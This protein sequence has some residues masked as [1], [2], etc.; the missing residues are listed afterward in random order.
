MMNLR[1]AVLVSIITAALLFYI[2]DTSA[3]DGDSVGVGDLECTTLIRLYDNGDPAA[4][5]VVLQKVE[6]WALGYMSGLNK[7]ASD[8]A[9]RELSYFAMADLGYNV[10][11]EC[12]ITP[13]R[14]IREIVADIY[15]SAS[16]MAPESV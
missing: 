9:K 15:S 1:N 2:P 11:S 13:A 12:R 10:L 3:N 6:Q 14:R 4:R 8:N 5:K 16:M 7:K